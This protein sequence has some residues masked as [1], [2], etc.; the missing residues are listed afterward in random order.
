MNTIFSNVGLLLFISL[1]IGLPTVDVTTDM[2]MII[3]LFKGA[4]GCVNPRW[5]SEDYKAW[6]NC[7][8]RV[9]ADDFCTDPDN[10]DP[11]LCK[12][13]VDSNFRPYPWSCQDPELWSP[14][15][16]LWYTCLNSPTSFC[17]GAHG[18]QDICAFD[19]HPKFAWSL[20]FPYF[21]NYCVC[22]AT[23]WRLER[24]K[25]ITFLFPLLNIYPQLG[26]CSQF[27]H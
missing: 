7:S 19:S 1:N 5:W 9:G 16:D 23:W 18:E 17:Q 11:N 4:Y 21:L 8:L 3:K 25:R 14:D 13:E 2:W 12:E 22:F 24:R 15:W 20:L 26:W 27:S 10:Y 6:E